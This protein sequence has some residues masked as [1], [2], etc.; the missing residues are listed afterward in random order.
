M[1]GES[2]HRALAEGTCALAFSLTSAVGLRGTREEL[3]LH[4]QSLHTGIF[5]PPRIELFTGSQGATIF[6][7]SMS[8]SQNW[9]EI[10]RMAKASIPGYISSN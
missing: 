7:F 3:A 8:V 1:A 6:I 5:S 9:Q 4:A 2:E 10:S